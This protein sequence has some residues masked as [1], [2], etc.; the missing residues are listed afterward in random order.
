MCYGYGRNNKQHNS[1]EECQIGVQNKAV[2]KF[3]GRENCRIQIEIVA[4]VQLIANI[5]FLLLKKL[6]LFCHRI[7]GPTKS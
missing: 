4:T 1:G 5:Q 6:P 2:I 7:A 3:K